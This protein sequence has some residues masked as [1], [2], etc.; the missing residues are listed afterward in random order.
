L[1]QVLS[2]S[3]SI[4]INFVHFLGSLKFSF[5]SFTISAWGI[6]LY[7]LCLVMVLGLLFARNKRILLGD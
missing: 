3:I 5:I 1:G 4:F 2:F 7:Y 6:G